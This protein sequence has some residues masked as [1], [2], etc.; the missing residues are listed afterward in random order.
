MLAMLA[1]F[2]SIDVFGDSGE[3]GDVDEDG[4]CGEVDDLARLMRLGTFA[5]DCWG[6]RCQ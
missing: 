1:M 3:V 6:W 4:D 2:V 5:G